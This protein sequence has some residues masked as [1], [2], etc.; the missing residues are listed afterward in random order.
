VSTCFSR[1]AAGHDVE[2][3]TFLIGDEDGVAVPTADAHRT[4]PSALNDQ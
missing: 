2:R 3:E 4:P 1:S